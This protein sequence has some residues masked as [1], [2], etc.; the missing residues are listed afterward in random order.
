MTT[1]P[2]ARPSIAASTYDLR[3]APISHALGRIARLNIQ[4]IELY[5]IPDAKALPHISSLLME[6]HLGV[7]CLNAG[8]Q[9]RVL[10][11]DES[12]VKHHVS[13]AIAAARELNSPFVNVY[14]GYRTDDSVFDNMFRFKRLMAPLLGEAQESGVGILLE[15]YYDPASYAD[16]ARGQHFMRTPDATLMLMDFIGHPALGVIWDPCNHYLAGVEPWP[17]AYSILRPVIRYVHAKSATRYVR[18]LHGDSPPGAMAIDTI[19]GSYFHVPIDQGAVNWWGILRQLRADSFGGTVLLEP[20]GAT[21]ND[22]ETGIRAGAAFVR[23]AFE[24]REETYLESG[25]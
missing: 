23:D 22:F 7:A 20:H 15:N 10:V 1:K 19:T 25:R 5:G 3:D 11:H 8:S 6:H 24:M 12:L 14:S 18:G 13:S 21:Q 16:D 9:I 2:A 4:S 17:F